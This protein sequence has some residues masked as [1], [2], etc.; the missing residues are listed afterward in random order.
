MPTTTTLRIVLLDSD[1]ETWCDWCALPCATTIT[2]VVELGERVPSTVRR[3]T[4]CEG[5]DDQAPL[6]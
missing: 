2:Y 4:F 1:T 6:R 3:L 5:C